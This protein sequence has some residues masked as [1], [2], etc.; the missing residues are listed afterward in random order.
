MNSVLRMPYARTFDMVLLWY[1]TIYPDTLLISPSTV[2]H[3]NCLEPMLIFI[4]RIKWATLILN[5]R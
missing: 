2:G 4:T 3:G 5:P 1:L